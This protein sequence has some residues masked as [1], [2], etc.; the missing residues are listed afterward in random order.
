MAVWFVRSIW[1]VLGAVLS[2]PACA[3]AAGEPL[4]PGQQALQLESGG[5]ARS[6]LLHL[7]PGHDASRRWPLVIMLHG[8]GGTGA[9][10]VRETGWSA[11][12]DSEGFMVAYPNAS[13]PD[14]AA[15]AS[16]R[17]N[18][19]AWADGSG[20]FHVARTHVDD[21]SFIRALIDRLIDEHGADRQRIYVTGFSNGA[22]MAFRVGVELADKVAAIAPVAGAFWLDDMRPQRAVSL[23]YISGT[24]DPLNPLDGGYP[25]MA[26]GGREQ[27]GRRKA[28]V[29]TAIEAWAAALGCSKPAASDE[30]ID[31][32]R[33][34]T[35]DSC[36]QDAE[37]KVVT[38]EGL[39]HIWAGGKNLLPE[40]MVGRPTDKLKATDA[41]W[42]F[43][44]RRA[45]Q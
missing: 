37:V 17:S 11:L 24:A 27:G 22:S 26:W 18:A 32:V 34:R 10:A 12:A 42:A 28:P 36:R 29:M 7:P 39:G 15:P 13:R 43:F 1:L 41:I 21:V 31:G 30:Q 8:M 19:P 16:L 44:R 3:G 9:N 20:R 4:R 33:T 40:F 23:F 45:M 14:P 38:V 2:L 6:F 25:K 5:M 35:F